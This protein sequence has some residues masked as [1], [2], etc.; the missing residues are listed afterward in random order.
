MGR[1][2]RNFERAIILDRAR[3][4]RDGIA[5]G[6]DIYGCAR[7][8]RPADGP[9]TIGHHQIIRW[10]R[11]NFIRAVDGRWQRIIARRI[12]QDHGQ[13]TA[14]LLRRRQSDGKI[15]V[16]AHHARA[17][18]G[19]DAGGIDFYRR[20]NFALTRQG[21]TARRNGQIRGG[22]RWDAICAQSIGH[23]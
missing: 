6:I 11:G 22:I 21:G 23:G 14:V 3:P 4:N 20:A 16:I 13:H 7:L 1:R 8:A 17:D 5:G 2:Q 9:A 10:Q 18:R 19:K 15:A 12:G